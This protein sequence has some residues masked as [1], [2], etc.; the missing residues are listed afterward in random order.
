ML[1]KCSF[2]TDAQ[3]YMELDQIAGTKNTVSYGREVFLQFLE[4]KGWKVD[5]IADIPD[6][7]PSAPLAEDTEGEEALA[8]EVVVNR[9]PKQH[10][11]FPSSSDSSR[12]AS[13]VVHQQ[14]EEKDDEKDEDQTSQPENDDDDDDYEEEEDDDDEDANRSQRAIRSHYAGRGN[15]Q[16]VRA[17]RK[18]AGL[19]ESFARGDPLLQEFAAFLRVSGAAAKDIANKVIHTI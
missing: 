15:V 14:D 3:I 2:T 10:I 17:A 1:A 13:P 4:S 8:E 7:E 6:V 19:N 16:A 18:K 5:K 11:I 9:G 12:V